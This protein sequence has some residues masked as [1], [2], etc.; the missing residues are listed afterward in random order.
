MQVAS[1]R[2]GALAVHCG[3]LPGSRSA[4]LGRRTDGAP[5]QTCSV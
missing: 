4:R 1:T 3:K 2:V 5:W